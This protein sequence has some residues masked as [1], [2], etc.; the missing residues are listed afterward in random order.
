MPKT[1]K[2]PT[3]LQAVR[4]RLTKAP[5]DYALLQQQATFAESPQDVESAMEEWSK[6]YA[7][8]QGVSSSCFLSLCMYVLSMTTGLT[9]AWLHRCMAALA[10][11][12]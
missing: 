3:T 8:P 11:P 5:Y 4:E 1:D 2:P 10:H 7:L 12:P 6:R 9:I